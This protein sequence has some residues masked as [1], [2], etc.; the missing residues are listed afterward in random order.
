MRNSLRYILSGALVTMTIAGASAK[1]AKQGIMSVPVADGKSVDVRLVGDEHFH[2]YLTPDGYPLIETE[3]GFNY[4]D[5]SA[6]GNVIDSRLEYTSVADR[7]AEDLSFLNRVDLKTLDSRIEK[8]ASLSPG[9]K[10]NAERAENMVDNLRRAA[11]R[12]QDGPPYPMGYGLFPNYQFPAYGNQKAIVILV[13]Y[14]DVK[15][16]SAYTVDAKD[17]FTKMLNQD[18]FID[19]RYGGTGSAAQ[20]FKE[21]SKGF[22]VPEF[23]VYGPLTLAHTQSYYGGNNF[24]GDDQYAYKMIIEAC[25]QLDPTVDFTQYDRDG[26]GI[27][28]NVF[29]IYAGRGEASGGGADSVWPHSFSLDDLR[30][31]K[32]FYD[33]VRLNSYG[34]SNEWEIERGKGRPDGVGTFIHEFSHVMGLPDLYMTAYGSAFT[35][36]NWSCLDYGPYLNE[37]R[38][39]PNYGAFERYALGWTW[40]RVFNKTDS[41]EIPPIENNIVYIANTEKETEFYLFENRQQTGWDTYIPGH[42]MLVWHIDYN[43]QRWAANT[44]NNSP[45]HQ[46]V[47]LVEAD[48][49]QTSLTIAGDSF[50]G[51]S[52]VTEFTADTK[53]AFVSWGG[54]PVDC[55]ITNIAESEE[56]L[57]TFDAYVEDEWEAPEIPAPNG[58]TQVIEDNDSLAVS[59]GYAMSSSAGMIRIFDASG[60]L[61]AKGYGRVRIPSAGLYIITLQDAGIARKVIVK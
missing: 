2:Q 37:G 6:D 25:D 54:I 36:G 50:P 17:Y 11:T 7:T 21:N 56:G 43:R 26:D 14:T 45:S 52:N 53:P 16:N 15:F 4:C 23:D 9:V 51:R 20:Y 32:T 29:V 8:R 61:V 30:L 40:P 35:P 49:Y 44:V 27:I 13:E 59:G 46:Y 55:A 22:F 41:Y 42:G 31:P 60:A 3:R 12:G 28:D 47:D 58:L 39:P 10:R 57:I 34:C 1:P 19:L 33:G 24:M 18:G 5:I 38:T 48:N